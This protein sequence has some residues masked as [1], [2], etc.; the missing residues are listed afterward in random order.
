MKKILVVCV[1][2]LLPCFLVS[3]QGADDAGTGVGLSVI[4]RIDL[5]PEFAEGNGSF[6]LGNSSLYSLF[7]GNIAEN[8]SFSVCNHWLST[9][10]S[11]L[12][13]IEG[14]G[15][16]LFRS[17]WTNWL[18][19]AYLSY[20]F[21]NLSVSLGK[22]VMFIGSFEFDAYDFEVHPQ[23]SSSL[24]NN[25]CCYQWGGK[26]AYMNE[27]ENTQ[28]SAQFS[29]SPYT[30]RPFEDGVL[31]AGLEWRGE[32]GPLSNIW[33][34]LFIGDGQAY[35]PVVSLGQRF[36]AGDFSIELDWTNRC[37]TDG[38]IYDILCPGNTLIGKLSY[39]PSETTELILSCGY[40]NNKTE[41]LIADSSFIEESLF[42][43]LAFHWSPVENLRLHAVA[44]LSTI[45]M[46][47]V[48]WN[49]SKNALTA[50]I[51]VGALYYFNLKLK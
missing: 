41:E 47:M 21:G 2:A 37:A 34:I 48:D 36:T 32:Y 8:F 44:S 28:I 43:G 7:E 31:S 49:I 51:G 16:N 13:T 4:P 3:A 17:D 15:A 40:E 1:A 18:D 46:G 12:Y 38:E 9:S 11:E 39:T 45:N 27:S 20:D 26:I 14:E 5:T 33:S 22:D 10:P 24:W 50:T 25:F 35:R 19:W 23:L 30:V 29:S 42:S 6:T